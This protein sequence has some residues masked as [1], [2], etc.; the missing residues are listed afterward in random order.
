MKKQ[1]LTAACA[2]FLTVGVAAAQVHITIGPPPRPREVVPPL[3]REHRD[4]VWH[5]G[6]HRW[7][8]RAYVWV[9]GEYVAPP[10][11]HARWVEG[12]WDHRHGEWIWVE[13]RWR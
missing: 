9:P 5:A 3:P 12:H 1:I 11:P 6:Y 8:G 13:G 4:W 10:H 7:D 2:L